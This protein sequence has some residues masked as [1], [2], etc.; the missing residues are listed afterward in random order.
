M[1]SPATAT[2]GPPPPTEPVPAGPGGS[3]TF[4][5][6]LWAELRHLGRHDGGAPAPPDASSVYARIGSYEPGKVLSALCFSGGGIRSATFNLGVLQAFAKLGLLDRFDY[7]SSVSGGGYIAGWLEKWLHVRPLATLSQILADP[8]RDPEVTPLQPEPKPIDYLREYSN[9]L[10]PRVGLFSADTWAAAA[11]IVRNLILNWLVLVPALAAIV[12]VPQLAL[13]IAAASPVA[14]PGQPNPTAGWGANALHTAV[15]LA[16]WAS[17]ATYHLRRDRNRP[18]TEKAVLVLVVVPLLLACLALAFAAL[19]LHA[20]GYDNPHLW[21]FCLLWCA[22]IP[23]FGWLLALVSTRGQ[24]GSPGVI[25]DLAG[26]VLSG[27]IV[28]VPLFVLTRSSLPALEARPPLFIVFAAP[29]L[30]GLYLLAR[31]LFVAF[32]SLGERRGPAPK[33][34]LD[35]AAPSATEIGHADREWWA[36]LSGWILLFAVAWLGGS[37]IVVLGQYL[38]TLIA[39]KAV[40]LIG[41]ASGLATALLG[42]SSSTS[43][44]SDRQDAPTSRV[45]EWSLLLLAPLT[46]V[47]V[48]I[49]LAEMNARLAG[50]LTGLP[51]SELR[52][53]GMS[54]RPT[55]PVGLDLADA[56]GGPFAG[57]VAAVL[58][59]WLLGWVVNVNRFSVH[60]I[61]RNRLVRAYLGASNPSRNPTRS[62]GSIRATTSPSPASSPAPAL[63]PAPSSWSTSTLN[64]V[65]RT[66][67]GLAAA[68]GRVVLDDPAL[69]RQLPRRLSPQPGVRELRRDLPRRR[70]HH[71]RRRRESEH[72]LSLLA[73]VTFLLSLFNVRLGCWLGNTNEHGAKRLQEQRTAAAWMSLFADL[74]GLTDARHAYVSLSDGGHFE[75]L[76]VYEMVLRRCRQI[77]VVDVGQDP[78]HSL[79]DL[80]NLVRKVRVDFGIPITFATPIAILPRVVAGSGLVCALG[81]I[82]YDEVDRGTPPGQLLYLKPTLRGPSRVPYDVFS[83]ARSSSDFPHQT[84]ADQWFNES[85]FE[86]YRALGQYL[87]ARL[88]EGVSTRDLPS[89]FEATREKLE[90]AAAA[91]GFTPLAI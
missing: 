62:R 17:A 26:I 27:G 2:G 11:L 10:T 20:E 44:K 52:V 4:P 50:F 29:I 60:G 18:A 78:T 76:G 81:T 25:S 1:T 5:Q 86:S 3:F 13:L 32:A 61:Y 8:T 41:G 68:Q 46:I 35:P 57:V 47:F 28:A 53:N 73:A 54:W 77:V 75:N 51:A 39:G 48:A 43:G 88:G 36:R 45:A 74:L 55:L 56:L 67:A 80:G 87:A 66:E 24:T 40:A 83:Y 31:S 64:L 30:L 69:L 7:L 49:G 72:G 91:P 22:G 16:L 70:H 38:L 59:S 42:A 12:A 58:V 82:G 90:H 37:A 71:L 9:Y 89:L 33:M 34:A 6:V 79:E 65:T 15:I 19:W 85:Q 14:G 21:G 84:T 63:P 23:L